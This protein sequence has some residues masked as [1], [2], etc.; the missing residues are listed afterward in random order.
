MVKRIPPRRRRSDVELQATCEHL[1]YEAWMLLETAQIQAQGFYTAIE[2]LNNAVLESF[3]I[4]V[5]NM[6]DF[7]YPPA[8]KR[9]SDVYATDFFDVPKEWEQLR[10]PMSYRLREA[11]ERGNKEIAHLT[12]D[13][14]HG[15]REQ[16]PWEYVDIANEITAIW[17]TFVAQVPPERLSLQLRS[18]Q[19][20]LQG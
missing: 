4:H 9:P 13:R 6:I 7:L 18:A 19:A 3:I 15:T 8:N 17:R 14:L 12:Y 2:P 1:A 10:P 5:R 20:L 16:K 11:R